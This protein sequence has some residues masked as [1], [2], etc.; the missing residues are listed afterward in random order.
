MTTYGIHICLLPFLPMPSV[1]PIKKLPSARTQFVVTVEPK[2]M[3]AAESAA[4]AR[5]GG[6]VTV[7]GFR[8]GKAPADKVK[9]KVNP[10]AL[11]EETVRQILPEAITNV[12]T[13]HKLQPILPPRVEVQSKDP[14]TIQ[15]T[16]VEKPDVKVKAVDKSKL[17][18]TPPKFDEKDV[19]RMVQYLLEQYRTVETVNRPADA[20]DQVTMDF[21]G[22]GA[23]GVELA[24]TR[25]TGYQVVLGSKTLI[26]GFEDGLMGVKAGDKKMLQLT[27]PDKYHAEQLQGKPVTFEVEVK[28]IEKVTTPV[29]TPEFIKEKGLGE[30]PEDVRKRIADS[31]HEEETR[32]DRDRREQM[33]FKMVTEATK[34]DIAPELLDQEA[35]MLAD[36]LSRRLEEQK[37]TFDDWLK[38]T[39]KTPEDVRKE[40][41]Q[42]ATRRIT[43]R[44][45]IQK[46]I[47]DANTEVTADELKQAATEVLATVPEEQKQ[48]AKAF[49]SEGGEGYEELRWRKKV[50]KWVEGMLN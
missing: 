4:L 6:N 28:G 18:K 3:L 27:F 10:D 20:G 42:E 43:M 1:S 24:G 8:P 9:E 26:P 48:Q 11:L 47:E 13:E 29:L 49:Y 23:D 41:A 32:M 31:M 16:L 46:L 44:Y 36:E 12:I 33:L 45:G 34:I 30:S 35:R 7:P 50:E 15:V 19:E 2:E 40:M 25:S 21:V 14:L 5:I 17:K 37:L 38:R 22:K 39:K